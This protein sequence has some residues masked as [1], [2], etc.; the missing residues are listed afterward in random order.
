MQ[1]ESLPGSILTILTAASSPV[2]ITRAC[3]NKEV[4]CTNSRRYHVL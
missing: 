1:Q 2:A 3:R 4:P